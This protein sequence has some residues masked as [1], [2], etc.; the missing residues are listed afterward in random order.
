[1]SN[2]EVAATTND[3]NLVGTDQDRGI[4]HGIGTYTPEQRDK[5]RA[6][7]NL[8]EASDADLDMLFAVAQRSG[9]DPMLKEIYLVGRKTKTGGYRGEPVR[10]ETVWTVQVGIDGFRKVTHRYA[11]SKG[12][13]VKIS[14]PI[15]YDEN[16]NA[17]PFWSK[18]FGDHPE[19]A[20]VT[21]TVGESS[22]TH[23]V[24]WDEYVQTKATWNNGKKV[25]EEPNSMWSQYG[26]TMLAKCAEAGGHRRVC[27]LTAG[28]YVP[29]ELQGNKAPYHA[30][31]TRLDQ[32][33]SAVEERNANTAAAIAEITA[34]PA[35]TA[36]QQELQDM[37]Q[38]Q[39]QPQGEPQPATA[40]QAPAQQQAQQAQQDD[41][42][43]RK[44]PWPTLPKTDNPDEDARL[45]TVINTEIKAAES[46]DEL[47]GIFAA[48]D[49]D[50]QGEHFATFTA[51]LNARD[52]DVK[53]GW[54]SPTN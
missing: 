48:Y 26:P 16:G 32:N 35:A 9:L 33:P 20:K 34:A 27:P 36:Q 6:V 43:Q 51:A 38:P 14:E 45:E 5:L 25:G 23:T 12:T 29:E 52:E 41:Q 2:N 53:N 40:Q 11:A 1:M 30:H 3:G 17:R 49:G 54:E 24:T 47:A 37:A 50:F 4:Q 22:A 8:G 39:Q 42:P 18:K 28:M 21:V 31:A 44:W 46:H 13:H 7:Q 15:F 10:Y 19:A